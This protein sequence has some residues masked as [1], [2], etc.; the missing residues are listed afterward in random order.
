MRLRSDRCD[1]PSWPSGRLAAGAD[2]G[3]GFADRQRY[4]SIERLQTSRAMI[5]YE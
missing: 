1:P 3:A 2:H 5:R 4:A